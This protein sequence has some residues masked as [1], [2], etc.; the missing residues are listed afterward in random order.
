MMPTHLT[1]RLIER[2]ISDCSTLPIAFALIVNL[3]IYESLPTFSKT[4]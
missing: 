3:E 1:R 4:A 2:T